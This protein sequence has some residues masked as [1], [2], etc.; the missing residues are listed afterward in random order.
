MDSLE[1]FNNYRY[2]QPD[3]EKAQKHTNIRDAIREVAD[4]LNDLLPESREKSIALTKLEEATMWANAS[5]ARN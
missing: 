2:H 5:L 1:I 3:K 4:Y